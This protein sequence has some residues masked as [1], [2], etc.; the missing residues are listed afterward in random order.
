MVVLALAV[1]AGIATASGSRPSSGDRGAPPAGLPLQVAAAADLEPALDEIVA[2]FRTAHPG[3]DI[4]VSYGSSGSFFAQISQGAP[5]DLFLSADI[6]YPRRLEASKLAR[7]G[8][9]FSYAAGRLVLWV[10]RESP[11]EVERLGLDALRD[12]RARHIALANPAHAPYGRAAEAALRA[13]GLYDDVRDRLV[14]GE[15]VSQATQFV[16]SGSADA[17]LIALSAALSPRLAGRGRYWLV[18]ESAYPRIVQTGV[19]L[20]RCPD[21]ARAWSFREWMRGP[22]ARGVLVRYGFTPIGTVPRRAGP[23]SARG[24]H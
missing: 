23:D 14:Y 15:N 22:E 18:P 19:I 3:P 11:L 12:P 24:G 9:K 16:Q 4:R 8:S 1:L 20:T 6:K 13:L 21:E 5:F 2:G 7:S 10:P 17:G